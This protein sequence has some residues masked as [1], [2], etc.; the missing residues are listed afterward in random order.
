MGTER[1]DLFL[2]VSSP[3]CTGPRFDDENLSTGGG[4]IGVRMENAEL[5]VS[6][7]PAK[8]VYEAVRSARP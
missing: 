3:V 1:A 5:V 6:R 4:G 2:S 7:L 8:N